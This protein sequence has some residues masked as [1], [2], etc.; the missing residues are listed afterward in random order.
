MKARNFRYFAMTAIFLTA[1]ACGGSKPEEKGLVEDLGSLMEGEPEVPAAAK[2]APEKVDVLFADNLLQVSKIRLEPGES[3][4]DVEANHRV[5]Y[6]PEGFTELEI[7]TDGETDAA[8]EENGAV[9]YVDIGTTTLTNNGSQPIEAIEVAR[10]DAPMPEFLENEAPELTPN[11]TTLFDND[12]VQVDELT[13]DPGATETM[14]QVPARLIYTPSE[15][16][17]RFQPTGGESIQFPSDPFTAY[18]RPGDD[19]SVTNDGENTVTFVIFD[20]FD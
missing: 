13:L 16:L 10:S 1:V 3:L 17:L 20:W 11:R 9:A 5:Y 7:D 12:V 19:I 14:P 15:S 8:L 2:A 18:A 4:P 6:R